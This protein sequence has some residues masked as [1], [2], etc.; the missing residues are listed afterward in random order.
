MESDPSIMGHCVTFSAQVCDGLDLF[1]DLHLTANATL[2]EYCGLG[3]RARSRRVG[4][5]RFNRAGLGEI[6]WG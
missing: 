5:A 1:N 4:M 3:T 2:S 6:G